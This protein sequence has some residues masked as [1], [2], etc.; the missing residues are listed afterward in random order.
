MARK[1]SGNPGFHILPTPVVTAS[2]MLTVG[3]SDS[4]W[5]G[6]SPI[7]V[8]Q[9]GGFARVM[10]PA[11]ATDEDIHHV[12]AALK[13]AGYTT[14]KVLP[15]PAAKVV[16]EGAHAAPA[17]VRATLRETVLTMVEESNAPDRDALRVAAEALMAEVGL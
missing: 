8:V 2:S 12:V 10:P 1:K 3:P 7:A 14:V 6:R 16:P 4:L 13:K 15:R 9:A 17:P 11:T 5:K